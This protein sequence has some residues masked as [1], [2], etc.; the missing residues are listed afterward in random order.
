MIIHTLGG[1]IY[2]Q[3]HKIQKFLKMCIFCVSLISLHHVL[4][5][6]QGLEQ[7]AITSASELMFS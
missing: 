1:T 2:V 6:L 4:F 7:M 5:Y 3:K